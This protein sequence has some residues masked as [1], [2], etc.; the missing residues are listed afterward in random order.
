MQSQTSS[1]GINE[2]VPTGRSRRA[3]AL[4]AIAATTVIAVGGLYLR[5][6]S[7]HPSPSAG[8]VD[9]NWTSA[10]AIEYDFASPSIGWAL[11]VVYAGEG[12]APG[13]GQPD[14]ARFTVFGTVDAAK[15]WRRQLTGVTPARIPVPYS[16]HFVN[17]RD[18]FVFIGG[19][20]AELY[21]TTDG[22]VDWTKI[23]S[24]PKPEVSLLLTAQDTSA[25]GYT[26]VAFTD[27]MHGWLI[28]GGQTGGGPINP[29]SPAPQLY[30]TGDGGATWRTLPVPPSDVT[31]AAF[32]NATEAWT[33][34]WGFGRPYIYASFD[35]GAT[36]QR[37][38]LP[39]PPGHPWTNDP[40]LGEVGM[41]TRVDLLPNAGVVAAVTDFGQHYL[42]ATSD[43][44]KTWNYVPPPPGPVLYVDSE[45]WWSI[46][47]GSLFKSA[48]GGMT[49]SQVSHSLPASSGM[50]VTVLD[51]DHAW[52]TFP[53][54]DGYALG[55]S[56]DGGLHWSRVQVPN[57]ESGS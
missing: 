4:I 1:D 52:A 18:G 29:G 49:W 26:G 47:G 50:N 46:T 11:L 13:A 34:G 27:P 48:D 40:S 31:L 53:V 5:L 3:V 20:A 56:T 57:P 55:V 22:G 17:P 44:G 42:F 21:R 43:M 9:R 41:P 54:V 23:E 32:R 36:W 8:S 37:H 19:S 15:H 28:A 39:S 33:G 38:Y 2:E 25:A 10:N 51:A 7:T 24:L 12:T 6:N 30:A 35:A 14:S 45:H 16:I